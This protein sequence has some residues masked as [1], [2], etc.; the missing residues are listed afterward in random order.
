MM[1]TPQAVLAGRKVKWTLEQLERENQQRVRIDWLRFTL[2][3]DAVVKSERSGLPKDL[4]YLDCLDKRARD[5]VR[6]TRGAD[7]DDYSSA[8]KVA[9]AGARMLCEALGCFEVGVVET[10]GMDYYTARTAISFAGETV[11]FVLAGGKS[12]NQASTVHVNLFG[13][14]LLHVSHAKLQRVR[15]WIELSNG[16]ITR[17][18]LALDLWTDWSVQ[19]ARQAYLDGEFKVRG[20][21]PSQR[22]HGSWTLGHSRTF[23]VGS[24]DTGKLARMYEKGDEQFGHEANDPWVRLEVEFRNNHRV[25][26]T[27]VIARPADF[28]AGAYPFCARVLDAVEVRAQVSVMVTTPEVADRTA[29]AAVTRLARWVR[30]T[31]MPSVLAVFKRTDGLFENLM[32]LEDD[33]GRIPKRI[34]GFD[35]S[36]ISAAFEKVAAALAP[37]L[38][39]SATGA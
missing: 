19:D 3:L 20:K 13:S 26:D 29:E 15:D 9:E 11:G 4:T 23:E 7:A 35:D 8:H 24:R 18:D 21:Q 22:E 34:R 12:S 37:P 14:A 30:D 32:R 1:T 36:S 10:R 33:K 38:A 17:V 27:A 31:A 39:P 5:L 25:I 6:E 28:F 16:W 2:P